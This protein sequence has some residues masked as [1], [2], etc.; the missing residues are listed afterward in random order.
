MLSGQN[1]AFFNGI[2]GDILTKMTCNQC[3]LVE[4]KQDNFMSLNFK[5]LQEEHVIQIRK[6]F[7]SEGYYEGLVTKTKENKNW[8]LFKIFTKKKEEPVLTIRDYL[9]YLNLIQTFQLSQFCTN[10]KEAHDHTVTKLLQK[11]P[12]IL[13]VGFSD[14]EEGTKGFCLDF[15]VDLEFD[16]SP[17]VS[18]AENKYELIAMIAKESTHFGLVS[19]TIYL[20]SA[21]G[22]WLKVDM[23]GCYHP[24]VRD[25][26]S[27]GNQIQL[28]QET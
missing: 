25:R 13:I 2:S 14:P 4:E 9:C 27:S 7:A 28:Y 11:T 5:L 10:C 16:I 26:G 8:K 15:K 12:E 1:S 19:D 17:F 6:R 20:K 21:S 24:Q 18:Q 23:Y 22:K 3:G